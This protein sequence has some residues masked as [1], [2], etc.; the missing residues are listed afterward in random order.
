MT[1]D[2]DYQLSW[3]FVIG[4]LLV[5]PYAASVCALLKSNKGGE[6]RATIR[7]YLRHFGDHFN[8]IMS[9]TI[10]I[11]FAHAILCFLGL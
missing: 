8:E 9:M 1:P 11:Y 3:D 7:N 10:V 5:I 6:Y 2:G 4:V